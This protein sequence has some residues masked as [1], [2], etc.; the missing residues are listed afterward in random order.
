M[1]LSMSWGKGM[2]LASQSL[3]YMLMEVKPGMVFTSLR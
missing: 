1:S 2:P 3:G